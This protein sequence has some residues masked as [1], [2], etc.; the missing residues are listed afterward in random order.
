MRI[1]GYASAEELVAT[2]TDIE[3]QLY[4]DPARRREFVRRLDAD[5]TLSQFESEV[6]RKDGAVIWISESAR[7]VHDPS[8]RLLY[9]EGVVEEITERKRVE[10]ALRETNTKLEAA[11]G[12][13]H[14]AQAQAI[15]QERLRL[16]GQMASGIAHDFNNLLSIIIG[17]TE[18]LGGYV[19][20]GPAARYVRE[21]RQAGDRAVTLTRRILAAGRRQVLTPEPLDLNVVVETVVPMLRRVIRADVELVTDLAPSAVGATVDPVQIE[22]AIMNLV[23]NARDAVSQ[24]GRITISTRVVAG[25][26][27]GWQADPGQ[28]YAVLSVEDDG[29]GMDPETRAHAFE[30][31]FTT[32][33]PGEGTGLGLAG[34]EGMARQSGG[35]V[36]LHSEPAVGTLVSVFLPG[37]GD[38]AAMPAEPAYAAKMPRGAENILLVE[39]EQHLR[40]LLAG[41]LSTAGYHVLEASNGAE[42]LAVAEAWPGPIHLVLTDVV[43][44]VMGGRELAGRIA[45]L[46]PG[47]R[48]LFMSGYTDELE[49][50]SGSRA[51]E[52]FLQKP[53]SPAVLATYVRE[54]LDAPL[55][56][57]SEL[58]TG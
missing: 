5:G 17:Y 58:S 57:G 40:A 37:S 49:L 28:L 45:E 18:I 48:V 3:S 23:V 19:G 29:C 20:E 52:T 50:T 25:A 54:L 21:I 31:F 32:K 11:V 30:P 55:A 7:A 51:P 56:R 14:A 36:D 4:V 34:V 1:Y 15:L 46:Y 2:L 44:P 41:A 39:D 43:M 16:V 35:F 8:G 9:Y 26:D 27:A 53:F 6:R 24:G 13:L 42:A 10:E 22:Q 47:S 38:T 33:A 12:E